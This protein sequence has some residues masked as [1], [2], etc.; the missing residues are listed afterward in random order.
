MNLNDFAEEKW[1]NFTKE[2]APCCEALGLSREEVENT[3]WE[4]ALRIFCLCKPYFGIVNEE[5]ENELL[6]FLETM[7]DDDEM[8]SNIRPV[9]LALKPA[10]RKKFWKYAAFFCKV[11]NELTS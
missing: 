10:Q 3:K 1:G 2:Y 7:I 11:V 4:S 8:A 6:A 5:H 9:Y